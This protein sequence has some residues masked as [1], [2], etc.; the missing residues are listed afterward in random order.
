MYSS[1]KPSEQ[2]SSLWLDAWIKLRKNR[3]ALF[4]FAENT[5]YCESSCGVNKMCSEGQG[6]FCRKNL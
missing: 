2:R 4:G 1:S 6:S 5:I 3:M